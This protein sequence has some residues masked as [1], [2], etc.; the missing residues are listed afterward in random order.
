MNK[1]STI[2]KNDILAADPCSKGIEYLE[3]YD[4][5][6][7]AWNHCT[8]PNHMFWA[9]R[10][11]APLDKETS[12]KLAVAFAERVLPIHEGKY[13]D[14]RPRAAL[15]SAKV[16]LAE[17]TATAA[18]AA[19]AAAY[20]A[21]YAACAACAART[22]AYDASYAAAYAAYAAANAAYAA[23]ANAAY[24][25]CDAASDAANDAANAA[26]NAAAEKRAQ[27]DIIRSLVSI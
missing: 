13:P 24:A 3:K 2:T 25:A 4:S 12:V 1:L 23:A 19:A 21:S 18:A 20:D 17:P 7:E 9:I 16:W 26:A 14:N 27:C 6:E 15:Q 5:L 10:I 11:F 8:E 22:A